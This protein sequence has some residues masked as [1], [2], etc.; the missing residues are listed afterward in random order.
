M[1]IHDGHRERMRKRIEE[2]GVESLQDHEILEFLLYYCV[3]RKDTNEI[4]HKILDSFGSLSEVFNASVERLQKIDGISY[5][6]AIF[7]S[8]L[9]GISRKYTSNKSGEVYINTVE[10]CVN[11]MRPIMSTLTREEIHMLL[12]DS[13]GKLIK[14]VVLNKGIVNES[15]CNVREIADI[16]LKNEASGVVLIHNH[17]SNVASPSFADQVMTEKIYLAL[18][19]LGIDL[20]DHIIIAKDEHYSFKQSG[21]FDKLCNGSV[22]FEGGRVKDIRY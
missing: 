11:V 14:R 17:P 20:D 15:V 13:A 21:M 18:T 5:N 7:L 1:A 2:Y 12:R 6:T 16:A 8:S 3:P 4:A 9:S 22:N 19:M 10:K